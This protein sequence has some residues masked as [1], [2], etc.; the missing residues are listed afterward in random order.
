[1]GWWWQVV[2]FVAVLREHA[3]VCDGSMGITINW[4]ARLDDQECRRSSEGGGVDN[5]RLK[6]DHVFTVLDVLGYCD[7]RTGFV[8]SRHIGGGDGS[9]SRLSNKV[10]WWTSLRSM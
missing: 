2:E 9:L 5:N 1:M 3:C 7:R 4:V 6:S 10:W 8:D